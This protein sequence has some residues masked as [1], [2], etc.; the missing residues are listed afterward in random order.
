MRKEYTHFVPE[1]DL[2]CERRRADTSVS[3]VEFKKE[4]T[5]VGTW[6]R[7]RIFSKEG[8][9]SIGRPIGQYDTLNLGRMD[10][11]DIDEVEDAKD[12]IAKELCLMCDLS[13]IDPSKILVVGLGNQSLTPD[14][15]G[16]EAAITVEATRHI[17]KYDPSL[18]SAMECSEISVVIPGVYANSGIDT[19]DIVQAITKEISPT[20]I[21]AIDALASRAPERLGTTVQISNTGI[22]PGSGLGHGRKAINERTTGTPVIAIGVPTI[23]DSRLFCGTK[24]SD[25]ELFVS[26][27]DIHLV[28]KNAARI[29]GGGI[30]QA[31]GM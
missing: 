11:M 3:G 15:I 24:S 2:A 23:I 29:I 27:K 25:N 26:P 14:A 12:E 28:V 31:F 8:A 7:I 22:F 4:K 20:L 6:E 18:F 13:S 16:A 30:N 17:R 5:R 10:L 21:F 1:S 19:A 9:E